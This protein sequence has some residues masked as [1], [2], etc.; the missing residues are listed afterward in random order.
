MGLNEADNINMFNA[1][2][3]LG[4]LIII[5]NKKFVTPWHFDSLYELL[6][7]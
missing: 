3:V 1:K 4:Q 6:N 5:K 2:T 7:S